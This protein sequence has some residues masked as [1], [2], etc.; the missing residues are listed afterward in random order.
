MFW[1]LKM[2]FTSWYF[3][4]SSWCG[5]CQL[6]GEKWNQFLYAT[7][8]LVTKM[9]DYWTTGWQSNPATTLSTRRQKTQRKTQ[10]TRR[11]DLL[12]SATTLTSWWIR[13]YPADNTTNW[14]QHTLFLAKIFWIGLDTHWTVVLQV[15]MMFIPW[16]WCSLCGL[17]SLGGEV[18]LQ[19]PLLSKSNYHLAM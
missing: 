16:I 14:W 6:K 4:W 3:Q 1:C 7:P 8:W 10:Q 15:F 11:Q 9:S 13:Y 18:Q 2:N 5:Q 12:K 19:F 17:L